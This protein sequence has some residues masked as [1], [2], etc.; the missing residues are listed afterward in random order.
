MKNNLF[1]SDKIEVRTVNDR[2]GVFCTSDIAKGELIEESHLILLDNN[3]WE[4]C[5]EAL[6]KYA[7]P[8][9]ELRPD[10]KDFCDEHGGILPV[11]AT[12]PTIVLGYGMIYNRSKN[13]NV[14]HKIEKKLFACYF[15]A[16]CDIKVDE[17]LLLTAGDPEVLNE[18][19]PT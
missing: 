7:F 14:D 15:T 19:Q 3:K 1:L 4:E 13:H 12:R 5:D 10:W 17:E 18:R 9:P 11:H 6:I 16:K 8:W 2:R